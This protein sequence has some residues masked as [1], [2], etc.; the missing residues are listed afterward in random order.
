[1]VARGMAYGRT[2]LSR[3]GDE[4]GVGQDYRRA[5]VLRAILRATGCG[6][7]MPGPNPFL[8][9]LAIL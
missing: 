4:T 6:S 2:G 9:G 7:G 3:L 5:G 1:M 8:C